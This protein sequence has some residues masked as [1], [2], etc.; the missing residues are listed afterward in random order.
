MIWWVYIGHDPTGPYENEADAIQA[1]EVIGS[2][3]LDERVE[4]VREPDYRLGTNGRD[5][6]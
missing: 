1:A 3:C 2:K 5:K 4:V 6:R